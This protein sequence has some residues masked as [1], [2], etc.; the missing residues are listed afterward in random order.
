MVSSTRTFSFFFEKRQKIYEKFVVF[1][2]GKHDFRLSWFCDCSHVIITVVRTR[3]EMIIIV[4]KQVRGK[5]MKGYWKCNEIVL[6]MYWDGL[7]AFSW[8]TQ[9]DKMSD[10]VLNHFEKNTQ[11]ST[12]KKVISLQF[13]FLKFSVE[14]WKINKYNVYYI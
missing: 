9:K 1:G 6:G 5:I 7:H 12:S 11:K 2:I 4:F 14:V 8:C 10:I 13:F 3:S